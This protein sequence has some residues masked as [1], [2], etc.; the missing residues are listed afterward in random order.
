MVA[1]PCDGQLRSTYPHANWPKVKEVFNTVVEPF[2]SLHKTCVLVRL[3][4]LSLAEF[5]VQEPERP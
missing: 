3:T 2:R 5:I 4:L 1:N